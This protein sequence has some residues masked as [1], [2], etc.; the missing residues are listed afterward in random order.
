MRCERLRANASVSAASVS[1]AS[2]SA[3]SAASVSAASAS[4]VHVSLPRSRAAWI[5]F[6]LGSLETNAAANLEPTADSAH[7]AD[8]ADSAHS[9]DSADSAEML[10]A[11]GSE[12]LFDADGSEDADID[13][14]VVIDEE[15]SADERK[16]D[17]HVLTAGVQHVRAENEAVAEARE[18]Q[19]RGG[20]RPR[21]SL[22]LQMD[23]VLVGLAC[24]FLS[25][26]CVILS[27]TL[28]RFYCQQ[29][30]CSSQVATEHALYALISHVRESQHVSLE[31]ARWIYC[32]LVKLD[33]VFIDLCFRVFF[34]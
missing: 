9:A 21:L 30:W 1:T 26:C 2:V 11:D 5:D 10:N 19:R 28:S 24:L 14:D 3:V 25:L 16:D 29:R 31:A 23:A 12:A 32:L 33:K 18:E 13:I 6:C 20:Q 27:T 17:A 4:S 22:L 15:E 7:S 8:S 34:C